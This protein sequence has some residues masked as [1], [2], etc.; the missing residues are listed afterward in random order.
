MRNQLRR[1]HGF[2]KAPNA[3]KSPAKFGITAVYSDEPILQPETSCD[4]ETDAIT[5]LNCAGYGSSLC[6]TA[7]FGM[8]AAALTLQ[9]I[10]QK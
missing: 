3:K 6:V 2:P 7:P 9:L 4:R 1:D 8:A 5:G 10:L